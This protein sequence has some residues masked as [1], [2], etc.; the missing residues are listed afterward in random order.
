MEDPREK[1]IF[2]RRCQSIRRKFEKLKENKEAAK[3]SR[4]QAITERR[5]QVSSKRESQQERVDQDSAIKHQSMP[6]KAVRENFE[7]LDTLQR[8]LAAMKPLEPS[9]I[10]SKSSIITSLSAG[11]PGTNKGLPS[12]HECAEQLKGRVSLIFYQKCLYAYNGRCYDLMSSSEDIIRLYRAK[13][14]NQ[15]GGEKTLGCIK[16]LYQYLLT[17]NGISVKKVNPNQ[18]IAV[19]RNGIYDVMSGQ[20]RKHSPKEIAFSWVDAEYHEN[21]NCKHFRRFL[22]DITGDNAD[23]QER[24][25]QSLGYILSQ[26]NEAKKLYSQGC[27]TVIQ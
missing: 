21:G 24:I 12:L 8:T 1:E 7:E 18:R 25:W 20:L 11:P 27:R 5:E 10:K 6:Q 13:V 16:Q 26:S 22:R 3:D 14:D 2:E 23:L 4:I 15:I 9:D 17:D 19:L